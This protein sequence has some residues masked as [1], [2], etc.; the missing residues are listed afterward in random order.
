MNG[1]RFWRFIFIISAS[2]FGL[3]GI[4]LAFIVFILKLAS[5]ENFGVSYLAPFSPFNPSA[6]K[7]AIVRFS[8]P[9]IFKRPSYIKIKNIRKQGEDNES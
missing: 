8:M 7:D 9:K 5:L 6:W 4:A 2:F 3:I 1:I